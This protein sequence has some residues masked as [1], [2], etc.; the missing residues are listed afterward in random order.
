MAASRWRAPEDVRAAGA[1]IGPNAILQLLPVVADRLGVDR[2]APL[3]AAADLAREPDG[4]SM[5]PE[6]DCVR[7]HRV[8]RSSEPTLSPRLLAEA[9]RRTGDYILAHRI[10]KPA[11]ALMRFLPAGLAAR[12]LARAITRH[13][14]TFAGSGRFRAV[15]PWQFEIAQNPFV[16]GEAADHPLCDWHAAVFERLYRALVDERCRCREDV[17][18]AQEGSGGIC[19]FSIWLEC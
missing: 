14:S 12:L 19:R 9:G 13:A 11:Q 3:M 4:A 16:L 8:V 5:V 15:T 6:A 18:G 1:R 10:P 2:V 7:L 17:C